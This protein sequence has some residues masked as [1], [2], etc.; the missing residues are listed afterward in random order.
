MPRLARMIGF[1]S[2]LVSLAVLGAGCAATATSASDDTQLSTMLP[3]KRVDPP[4]PGENS[5]WIEFQDQTGQGI[6]LYDDLVL[7]VQSKG[8]EPVG[9]FETADYVLWATLRIFDKQDENFHSR[10]AALGGIAGGMA[11]AGAVYQATGN[12]WVAGG[13]GLGAGTAAGVVIAKATREVAWGMVVDVQLGKKVDGGVEVERSTGRDADGTSATAMGTQIGAE[14]GR[15][16]DSESSSASMTETRT[17]FELEQRIL[18][19]T[20]GR[21]M[22][23]EVAYDA[24]TPR[25]RN[26]LGSLLARAR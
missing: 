9:D 5:V 18:A 20:K 1:A 3:A 19:S 4:R 26:A 8:Y 2:I 14:S 25:L 10:L 24:I 16:T 13:A 22:S 21:R 23:R 7:A 15:S 17:R 6:D 11:G 12:W